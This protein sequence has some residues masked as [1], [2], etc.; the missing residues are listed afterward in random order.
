MEARKFE[1]VE[2]SGKDSRSI[3][4]LYHT[5]VGRGVLRVLVN[6]AC[7]KMCGV[8]LDSRAS[9]VLIPG[10]VR[11][12]RIEMQEYQD[13]KYRSFNDFFTREVK[14]G[15]RPISQ[16]AE[17]LIAPCDG[18][19]T[20]YPITEDSV[21]FIK[22][23]MY[24]VAGLLADRQLAAEYAGG[25]CV[26]LR[27]SPDDYHRY[28]YLDDGELLQERRIKG[29]LHTVRPIAFE[30]YKVFIQNAREFA[31]LKT[32]N[33]GK[34]VQMEVGALLIGRIKN[35]RGKTHFVRG[36][37]RGM[38]EFGGS[39]VVLLFQKDTV[40]IHDRFFQ[41]TA[42]NKETIVLMGDLLGKKAGSENSR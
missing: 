15:G 1:T 22:N 24:S 16:K 35:H 25:C 41:N 30:R 20:A 13:V 37:E 2:I 23:S 34:V 40:C 6:P 31:L 38:F 12:N 3:N 18:K 5:S 28:C 21:F 32:K 36:E 4:F 9:R 8:L 33:F 42:E 17:D 7:S 26:I 29:V 14:D 19:V 11:H 27:L 39:T 10:F